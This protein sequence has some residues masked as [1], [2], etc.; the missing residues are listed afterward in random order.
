MRSPLKVT[1][2]ALLCNTTPNSETMLTKV[3]QGT[4]SGGEKTP[5]P[6]AHLRKGTSDLTNRMEYRLKMS[7][8][9]LIAI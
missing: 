9:A 8:L 3:E 7:Y 2:S 6:T 4:N 5:S 1:H